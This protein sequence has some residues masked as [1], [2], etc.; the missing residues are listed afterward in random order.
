MITIAIAKILG[1]YLFITGLAV[2]LKRKEIMLAVVSLF[3][4]QAARFIGA[5][6]ALLF[7]LIIISV[8]NDWST[9]PAALVSF[10]GW[11]GVVK[12][13]AYLFLKEDV[14]A[15]LTEKLLTRRWYLIDGL[16]AVGIGLYLANYAYGWF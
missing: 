8:H 11:G 2:L 3:K 7:G 12:G 6:M 14:I 5:L 4:E 10:F 9:L 13:V 16:V 1:P 15:R